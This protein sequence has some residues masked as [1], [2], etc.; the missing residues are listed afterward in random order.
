MQG[1]PGPDPGLQSGRK[2]L[3]PFGTARSQY[4]ATAD[5]F[6]ACAEAV[7][8]LADQHARLIGALHRSLRLE[9]ANARGNR[10][11]V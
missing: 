7:T 4:L 1:A 8:S 10:P 3:A 2:A 5:C 9:A 6:H 11:G